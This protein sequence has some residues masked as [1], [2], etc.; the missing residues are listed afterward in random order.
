MGLF[1]GVSV[2]KL[3]EAQ[4]HE[5]IG[6]PAR[7]APWIV[8]K[9]DVGN[10]DV[11][12]VT[13]SFAGGVLEVQLR[14]RQTKFGSPV[15]IEVVAKTIAGEEIVVVVDLAADEPVAPHRAHE[16]TGMVRAVE[17]TCADERFAATGVAWVVEFL[18][19]DQAI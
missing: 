15:V 11:V 16:P 13:E 18:A 19:E 10:E 1:S 3:A 9:I 12:G 2:V 14:E 4:A 7:I 17:P 6:P 8:E 5:Y